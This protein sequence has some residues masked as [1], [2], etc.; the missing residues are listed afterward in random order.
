MSRPSARRSR[1]RTENLSEISDPRFANDPQTIDF[2]EA[3][4]RLLR[5][6]LLGDAGESGK[7]NARPPFEEVLAWLTR[8]RVVREARRARCDSG[9]EDADAGLTVAALRY[10]WASHVGYLRDLVISMLTPR[11][12]RPTEIGY[13]SAIIDAVRRRRRRL[14]D[15]IDEI[16]ATE[17]QA[18]R[19]DRGFRLQMI[20]QTTLA[21]DGRVA[22]A[23]S[24]IDQANV[25]GWTEF[26]RQSYAK[27]GLAPRPGI[28]FAQLGCALEAAGEGVMIRSMLAPTADRNPPAPAELLALIAKALVIATADAG[29][30]MT[31]DEL[32]DRFARQRLPESAES[33]DSPA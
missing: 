1:I 11:M 23:L 30:G 24:D 9:D 25:E 12:E 3:G 14:P 6:D 27:L 31:L 26:A 19:E 33:G 7:V 13:A 28:D 16:A 22:A 15:A 8:D 10:R 17:V 20:F 29:D 18:L 5:N 2:L 4:E 32:L 21:H